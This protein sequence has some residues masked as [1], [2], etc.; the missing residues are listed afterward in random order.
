MT[1]QGQGSKGTPHTAAEDPTLKDRASE[2]YEVARDRL[3]SA[4]DKAAAGL[5]ANPVIALAGGLA[6]GVIAGALLPRTEREEALLGGVG[7]RV[8][9]GAKAALAAAREAGEAKLDELGINRDAAREQ[10]QKFFSTLGEVAGSAGEAA[11]KA[12]RSGSAS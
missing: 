6:L 12:A 1:K 8:T 10:A 9:D 5:D 11:A 3:S 7:G 4:T 2:A